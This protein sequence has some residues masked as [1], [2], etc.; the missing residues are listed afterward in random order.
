MPSKTISLEVDA[1]ERLK[2]TR[3]AG[4]SFSEV[5][6][7]I[8]LPPAKAT[9]AELLRDVKSGTFGRGVDWTAVKRAV[10]GRRH[11]REVRSA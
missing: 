1:Y 5:V 2:A 6:R 10:A 3:R 9:A 7:R 8:T 4:E 11:S